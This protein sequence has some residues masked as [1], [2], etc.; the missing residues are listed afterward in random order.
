MKGRKLIL[1]R[2]NVKRSFVDHVRKRILLGAHR[3]FTDRQHQKNLCLKC[4]EDGNMYTALHLSAIKG[5]V[6]ECVHL[7]QQGVNVNAKDISLKSPLHHAVINHR[8]KVVETLLVWGADVNA[9]DG[10]GLAPL[11]YSISTNDPKIAFVLLEYNANP[12]KVSPCPP[13]CLALM[14]KRFDI[15]TELIDKKADPNA[16]TARGSSALHIASESGRSDIVRRLID[17]GA[18]VSVTDGDGNTPLHRAAVSTITTAGKLQTVQLLLRHGANPYL[19]NGQGRT[20][21]ELAIDDA[22]A[23]VLR[24]RMRVNSLFD[25]A[26]RVC[27]ASVP[28]W[29]TVLPGHLVRQFNTY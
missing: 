14:L 7:I 20:A 11:Y 9:M 4:D 8:G 24:Q 10:E 21:L 12:N 22:L 28:S 3:S 27:R 23:A 26:M 19:R 29:Q 16:K 1:S 15:A 5:R 18:I 2:A 13:L 17:A 25:I 6:Q